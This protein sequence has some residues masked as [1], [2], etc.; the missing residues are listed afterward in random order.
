MTELNLLINSLEKVLENYH[1]TG[2]IDTALE[3]E[4]NRL[5]NV[6]RIRRQKMDELFRTK[7]I[8]K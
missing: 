2:E 4:I 8:R 5:K 1:L 7:L 3:T 6:K